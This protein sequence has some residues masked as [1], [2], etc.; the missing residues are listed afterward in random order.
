MEYLKDIDFQVVVFTPQ[1]NPDL[2][3]SYLK[4]HNAVLEKLN[5]GFIPSSK[6]WMESNN[7]FCFGLLHPTKE[8][9]LI[10]GL[11][12]QIKEKDPLP[13]ETSLRNLSKKVVTLVNRLNNEGVVAEMCGLWIDP[14][15]SKQGLPKKLSLYAVNYLSTLPISDLLIFY[16]T[17]TQGI[18]EEI[19][20]KRISDLE[21]KGVFPYPTSQYL[22]FVGHLKLKESI[23]N[24]K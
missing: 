17:Y 2:A 24:E 10:S 9:E 19:G 8:K 13:V 12:V 4:S 5:L 1:N 22:S 18:V 11:K 15:F 3:N 6:N 16:S 23:K 21:N 20:F 14:C 7:V